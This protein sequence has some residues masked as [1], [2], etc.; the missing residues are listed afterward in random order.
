MRFVSCTIT[1]DR[2]GQPG[3]SIRVGRATTEILL[4]LPRVGGTASV[5][6]PKSGRGARKTCLFVCEAFV[7]HVAKPTLKAHLL[8]ARS[9]P[10]LALQLGRGPR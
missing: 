1:P 8:A 6:M 3:R 7:H 4:Q 9:L 5:R 2:V 10:V